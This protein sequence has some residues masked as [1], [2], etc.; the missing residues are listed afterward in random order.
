M[1]KVLI[2]AVLT[3]LL[4]TGCDNSCGVSS[5]TTTDNNIQ[6]TS[7][8]QGELDAWEREIY[9]NDLYNKYVQ[10]LNDEETFYNIYYY[11]ENN[12]DANNAKIAAEK[13]L[14]SLE[15]LSAAEAPD[16]LIQ[17]HEDLVKAVQHERQYYEN[18]ISLLSYACGYITLTDEET[19]QINK[20][21]DEYLSIEGSPLSEA[22]IAVVE[23][24]SSC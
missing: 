14:Q 13:C 15:A 21:I 19:E 24:V 10:Y 9:I 18:L 22:F 7:S 3:V 2:S 16:I 8:A 4:L 17:Y 12:D 1:K 23:T 5:A 11:I 20:E 6:D